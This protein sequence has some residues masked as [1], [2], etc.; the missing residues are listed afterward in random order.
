MTPV[1]RARLS[2]LVTRQGGRIVFEQ[3]LAELTTWAIGGPAEAVV[4][5]TTRETLREVVALAAAEGWLWRVM[6]NGS[7]LL[8]PDEG[9]RGLVLNLTNSLAGIEWREPELQAEGGVFLPKLAREAASRGLA[10]LECVV[11]VPG[12]VGGGCVMNAGVPDGTLGDVLVEVELLLPDGTVETRPAEALGLGHRESRLQREQAVVLAARLRLRPDDPTAIAARMDHHM[13]HRRRTQPLHEKTCGSVFRRPAEDYPGR[14]I[15]LAGCKGLRV[16]DAEVSALHANWI[17]NRGGATAADVR[18]LMAE[19]V[20]R[21]ER[22][23]GVTLVPEVI[24]W[25]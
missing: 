3:P 25:E 17:E 20:A 13:A 8:C 6:G 18:R 10:G 11:G 14:L 4:Y 21:V 19:I 9:V 2:D 24:V 23:F 15:E 22:Q 1:D 7:N 12:T 16:G 5:P